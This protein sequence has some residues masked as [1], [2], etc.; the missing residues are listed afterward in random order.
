MDLLKDSKMSR[1]S[2]SFVMIYIINKMLVLLKNH[3]NFLNTI[4]ECIFKKFNRLF[5]FFKYNFS[6]TY[7]HGKFKSL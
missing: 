4:F 7:S 2:F 3:L 1:L 5:F 6:I